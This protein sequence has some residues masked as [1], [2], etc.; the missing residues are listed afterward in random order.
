[1]L[2]VSMGAALYLP[3]VESH[4]LTTELQALAAGGFELVATVLDPAA[5]PLAGFQRRKRTA[6][7]FGSEGH[8][9]SDEWLTLCQRRVTIPMQ[10]GIDSL[11]V[12]VAA[13]VVLWRLTS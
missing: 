3:I 9:L 6:I 5:E 12:A 10:A 1:V 2:R 11:N 13:A 7:L 4:N 8:G